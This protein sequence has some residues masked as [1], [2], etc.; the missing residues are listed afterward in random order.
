MKSVTH[1]GAEFS[2][3]DDENQFFNTL[4]SLT[5]H[6]IYT[7]PSSLKLSHIFLTT[8]GCHNWRISFLLHFFP[9]GFHWLIR[10]FPGHS[11]KSAVILME[12]LGW[13]EKIKSQIDNVRV[14]NSYMIWMHWVAELAEIIRSVSAMKL[15]NQASPIIQ[16]LK[17]S[18]LT[19]SSVPHFFLRS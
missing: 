8:L 7:Q 19:I 1:V 15:L 11:G 3:E 4:T 6:G 13:P 16:N 5:C 14:L 9:V 12:F 17:S 10:L 18:Y 2:T